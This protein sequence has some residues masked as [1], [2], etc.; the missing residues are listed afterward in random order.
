MTDRITRSIGTVP[1]I[2]AA[3]FGL[4]LAA[5]NTSPAELSAL[6]AGAGGAAQSDSIL[7]NYFERLDR[8]SGG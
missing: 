2:F 1:L 7:D 5:C 6:D 4:A 3:V 8:Q